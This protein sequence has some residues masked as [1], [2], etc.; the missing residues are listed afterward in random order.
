M[1]HDIHAREITN[2]RLRDGQRFSLVE[3]A[4]AERRERRKAGRKSQG[5]AAQRPEAAPQG[6][7]A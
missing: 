6:S 7:P 5:R 3:R 4:V 1:L 2:Q